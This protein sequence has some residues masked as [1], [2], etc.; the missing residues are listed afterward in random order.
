MRA[1]LWY[2]SCDQPY[3]SHILL[4]KRSSYFTSRRQGTMNFLAIGGLCYM[5]SGLGFVFVFVMR[6]SLLETFEMCESHS[7]AWTCRAMPI[8]CAGL[9][10]CLQ[11]RASYGSSLKRTDWAI[12]ASVLTLNDPILLMTIGI[13]S[14]SAF[15]LPW[16]WRGCFS[17]SYMVHMWS[18]TPCVFLSVEYLH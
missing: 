12:S 15:R 3:V 6:I 8:F 5:L 13:M 18:M 10:S 16:V 7:F 17:G 14:M 1:R 11:E 9:G 2:A 4:L